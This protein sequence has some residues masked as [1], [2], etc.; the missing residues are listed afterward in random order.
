MA[1]S[2]TTTRFA[3]SFGASPQ[4]A[5]ELE[6]VLLD[7]ALARRDALRA[8][9]GV[10]HRPAD[11]HRVGLGEQVLEDLDLVGDLRAADEGDEGPRGVAERLAEVLDLLLDQEPGRL[12]L[13]EPRHAGGRRVGA[14][15]G[16]ERVVH[17]D[18]GDRGELLRERLVVLLLLR[19]EAEV[20]E[21][22]DLTVLEV[23]HELLH[24]VADA[25]VGEDDVLLQ[26]LG[27]ALRRGLEGEL[28]PIL[29]LPL[30]APQVRGQDHLRLV[31]DGVADRRERSPDPRVVG[32][33]P[34][35]V[36]GDVEVDAD[37]DALAREVEGVDG[38][39]GHGAL[40]S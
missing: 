32:H 3:S 38:A 9:E 11:A 13:H 31:V 26:Q 7:E 35:L 10:R 14:V 4:M 15:G 1:R 21:E 2:F 20:L 33:P 34:L 40:T 5:G 18:V 28:L 30:R 24:P 23:L 25:V 17:P 29:G 8:E 6:L 12:L 27:Q 16:A 39:E 19:V 36:E 22:Q 37:E